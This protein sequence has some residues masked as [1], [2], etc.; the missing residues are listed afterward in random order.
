M[1][2]TFDDG[3]SGGTPELLD[4]LREQG[5]RATF[6]VCGVNVRRR[7]ETARAAVAGGHEL[8][9]HTWSHRRLC[10]RPGWRINLLRPAAVFDEIGRAQAEL[11]TATGVWPRLVRAPYGLRWWGMRRA[12]RRFGLLHVL[13]TT[14]GHDWEWDAEQVAAHVLRTARPGGIVCLHDGRDTRGDADITVTLAAV[15]R[16]VPELKRLGYSFETVSELLRPDGMAQLGHM[17]SAA[18]SS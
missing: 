2:L 9:N 4:Y 13:W 5:V 7:P 15:R 6:F 8:A 16:I 11:F 12:Q 14:I 1:A 10:P 3:P 17:Q 18:L